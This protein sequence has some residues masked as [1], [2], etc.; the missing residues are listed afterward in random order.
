MQTS[1]WLGVLAFWIVILF[2]MAWHCSRELRRY[3]CFGLGHTVA[4][5]FKLACL[6]CRYPD[7]VLRLGLIVSYGVGLAL[8]PKPVSMR[9]LRLM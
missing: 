3:L 7:H 6:V 5:L 1:T 8:K 2:V 4:A 9:V